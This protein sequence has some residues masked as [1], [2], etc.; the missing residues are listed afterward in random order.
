GEQDQVWIGTYQQ[1]L[2]HYNLKSN[3]YKFIQAGNGPNDL[4]N[5]EIFCLTKDYQGNLWIGTNGG[6]VNILNTKDGTVRKYVGQ[7]RNEKANIEPSNNFVRAFKEDSDRNMWIGS[8]GSGL[9]VYNPRTQK[10]TF[11]DRENSGLPSNYILS[12]HI[13]KLGTI[14]VG[15]NGNGVGVL[16][17]GANKFEVISEKDG[18]INGVTQSIVEADNGKI[19]FSTNRGLSC[20]DPQQKIFKNYTQSA[21]LQQ[22]SYMLGAGIKTSDGEIFFGGQNGFN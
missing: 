12:I 14:W 4:N 1:G 21:G 18:L 2:I 6:G 8:Y 10:T 19:W 9:S 11:Y 15:T 7:N 3:S 22:G 13:D 17:K 20:Y 5:N 16:R